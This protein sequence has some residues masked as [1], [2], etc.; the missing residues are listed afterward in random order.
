MYFIIVLLWKISF[1]VCFY[2]Q[3][4]CR[5]GNNHFDV[6]FRRIGPIFFRR[7]ME[8]TRSVKEEIDGEVF[9]SAKVGI[10]PFINNMIKVFF[11]VCTLIWRVN[12]Y[13]SR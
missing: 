5:R 8:K 7:K 13:V 9:I 6:R 10:F 3:L 1:I 2:Y 4:L 11:P 12:N